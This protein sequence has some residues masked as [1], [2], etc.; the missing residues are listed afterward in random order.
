MDPDI[1][2]L[3]IDTDKPYQDIDIVQKAS[4]D[5][6]PVELHADDPGLIIYTSGT[7]GK[8]KGAVLTQLNLI[9]DARNIITIWEISRADTLCHA[10]PL[11]HVHGLCFALHTALLAGG[12]VVMLDQFSP[13][14]V[15][16]TLRR[17]DGPVCVR[18]LWRC[19]PCTP[20]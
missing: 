14:R 1:T 5:F 4:E 20:N 9:H 3:I 11:F 12:H 15:I 10:L 18:F 16:E 19:R 6:T 13:R 2:R 8:P 7:T 17:K